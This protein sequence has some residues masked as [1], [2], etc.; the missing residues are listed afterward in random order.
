VR[1]GRCPGC[2]YD[3][4]LVDVYRC[5]CGQRHAKLRQAYLA[6]TSV[7][8]LPVIST[9]VRTHE[10]GR[11]LRPLDSHALEGKSA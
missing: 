2:R 1:L 5:G 9:V 3:M 6:R 8:P 4:V 11:R 10:C 7:C